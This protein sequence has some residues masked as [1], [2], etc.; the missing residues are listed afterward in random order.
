M[1]VG[2]IM[3]QAFLNPKATI[4]EAVDVSARIFL[5]LCY[6][7]QVLLLACNARIRL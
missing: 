7:T 3:S 1:L 2:A 4:K 5:L 6:S